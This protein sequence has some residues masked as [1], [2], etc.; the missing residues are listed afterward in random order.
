MLNLKNLRFG[1]LTVIKRAGTASNRH[2]LWLCICD[3]GNTTIVQSSK[4]KMGLSTSC[5][6][7]RVKHGH[8]KNKQSSKIYKAWSLMI[9]RCTNKKH[10]HYSNYGGRGIVVCDRWKKFVNFLADMGLPPTSRHT[11]DRIDNNG[12]YCPENC[13]WSTMLEQSRNKRNNRWI[14]FNN[15]KQTVSEWSRETGL[16][17]QTILY[18]LKAG[19]SIKRS[20]THKTKAKID[21]Q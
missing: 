7:N 5:G 14:T 17:I 3:C 21:N 8:S 9:Q 2:V 20:L 18:R 19:W 6:C 4:L 16:S 12:H 15:K 1:K 10:R 11:I 13:K